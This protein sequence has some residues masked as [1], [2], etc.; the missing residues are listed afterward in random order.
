MKPVKLKSVRCTCLDTGETLT[1]ASHTPREAMESLIYFLNLHHRD[2]NAQVSELGGGRTL[3][4]T[5]CGQT[6]S[7]TNTEVFT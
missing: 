3:S 7:T 5:H 2:E 6:W 4:V 1:F